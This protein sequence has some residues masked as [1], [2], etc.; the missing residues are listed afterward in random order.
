MALRQTWSGLGRKQQS[1]PLTSKGS[2]ILAAVP[3]GTIYSKGF[4][5]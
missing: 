4:G 1:E 3:I 2:S 5:W